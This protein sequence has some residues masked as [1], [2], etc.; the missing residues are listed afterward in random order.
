MLVTCLED[1]V[2]T[3]KVDSARPLDVVEDLPEA[4]DG[5]H[6]GEVPL[7]HVPS[8]SLGSALVTKVL[9]TIAH[10]VPATNI[11]CQFPPSGSMSF[12]QNVQA[13]S[14]GWGIAA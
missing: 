5:V 7:T 1:A 8:L 11:K 13:F 12:Y 14:R 9:E 2:V 6:G 3:A 10:K 4:L